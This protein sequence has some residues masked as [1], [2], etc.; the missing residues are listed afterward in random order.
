MPRAQC[1]P[2][3]ALSLPQVFSSMSDITGKGPR[4]P[5]EGSIWKPLDGATYAAL[6]LRP[7]PEALLSPK[8]EALLR[9]P[10]ELI[11]TSH[12]EP[13]QILSWSQLCSVELLSSS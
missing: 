7:L 4:A 3:P 2:L 10:G 13:A 8:Q 1:W 9:R 12:P 11:P 6:G 5:G